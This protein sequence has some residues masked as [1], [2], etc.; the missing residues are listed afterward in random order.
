MGEELSGA[1]VER[2]AIERFVDVRDD[3]GSSVGAWQAA[4]SAWAAI[5]P[6]GNGTAQGEAR[7][8]RR[9]WR[10][11][12]RANPDLGLTSRL[13]WRGQ[14]L[15]VLSIDSDPRRPDRTVLRCEAR[16]G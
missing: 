4:G 7:R 9:R 12:L 6:D 8:S 5:V 15:A 3:S 14:W 10:V 1:L 13:V 2:V 11:T 16:V